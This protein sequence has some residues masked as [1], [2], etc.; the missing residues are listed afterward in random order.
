MKEGGTIII[1][2][3]C[4]EGIGSKEFT[5]LVKE[6]SDLDKFLHKIFHEN[7]FV[8]DQWQLQEYAKVAKKAHIILVSGGLTL[9]Q[10]DSIH[11]PWAETVEDALKISFER[12]GKNAKIAVIPK[13]PY[14]LAEI[15]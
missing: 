1:A 14:I 10:K 5:Q 11:V 8:I 13:G 9:E 2:S 3:E 7:Y 15:K 4:S 6:S 12:H